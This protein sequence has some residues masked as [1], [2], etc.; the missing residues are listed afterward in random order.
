M[1]D[2]EARE[3]VAT[4][5]RGIAP[6]VDLAEVDLDATLQEELDLD[7]IDFLNLMTGVHERT[8]IDVPEADYG[9]LATLN[10]CI[11]YLTARAT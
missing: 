9:Q 11:A 1:T 7:S 4:V 5:L 3:V 2:D 10:G 6:E 8:G